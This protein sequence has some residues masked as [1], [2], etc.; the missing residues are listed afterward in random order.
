MSTQKSIEPLTSTQSERSAQLRG[1]YGSEAIELEVNALYE[2]H[3]VFDYVVDPEA[4][5]PRDRLV[6]LARSVRDILSQRWIKTGKTALR[7]IPEEISGLSAAVDDGKQRDKGAIY[8]TW[9]GWSGKD[10]VEHGTAAPAGRS[11]V[12]SFRQLP[13]GS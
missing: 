7:A 2:R 12:R 10:G 4:A 5:G 13:E 6:A 9:N 11:P 3:L 8:A 1:Q